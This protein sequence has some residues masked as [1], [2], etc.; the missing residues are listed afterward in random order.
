MFAY[1]HAPAKPRPPG[2]P[3]P[4]TQEWYRIALTEPGGPLGSMYV[5]AKRRLAQL[6]FKPEFETWINEWGSL[7][8]PAPAEIDEIRSLMIDGQ[9]CLTVEQVRERERRFYA[10]AEGDILTIAAVRACRRAIE[11]G[12]MWEL[13]YR[14]LK[15]NPAVVQWFADKGE[16]AWRGSKSGGA[17]RTTADR[18]R[19]LAAEFER[20]RSKG[21]KLSAT[22]LMDAIGAENDMKPAAARKA[23][24]RALKK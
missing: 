21:T 7:K 1:R 17:E 13:A 20:R 11:A 8:Y 23:I 9:P 15:L 3:V 4:G 19:K 24:G 14:L 5:E 12:H 10:L 6:D 18:D 22:A 2:S 16:K